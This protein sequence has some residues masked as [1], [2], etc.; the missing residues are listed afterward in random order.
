MEISRFIP[1]GKLLTVVYDPGAWYSWA[2]PQ[3]KRFSISTFNSGYK[4]WH[5]LCSPQFK[6]ELLSLFPQGQ[7]DR[8]LQS[9]KLRGIDID[10]SAEKVAIALDGLC[11]E[12]SL[13]TFEKYSSLAADLAEHL[14]AVNN[15]QKSIDFSVQNPPYVREV[16]YSS[17]KK[18]VE[19][20]LRRD[21][22]LYKLIAA[23]L[24]D[25][26]IDKCGVVLVALKSHFELLT[27]MSAAVVI[28]E[29]FPSAH[30]S[31]AEHRYEYFSLD[32]YMGKLKK[33]GT[34]LKI[35]DSVV[36]QG[37]GSQGVIA[38]MLERLY[39]KK[40]VSG[41]INV[42]SFKKIPNPLSSVRVPPDY[43]STF[44][45]EPLLWTR[46]SPAGC[47][48]GKCVFCA[49]GHQGDPG[50]PMTFFDAELATQYLADCAAAGYRKFSFS[51]EAIEAANLKQLCNK[52]LK[53]KLDIIWSCRCR[54]DM[55]ASPKLF[56]LMHSAGCREILFGLETI[57]E[58]VQKLMHKYDCYISP[59]TVQKLFYS[60][61]EA[62]IGIHLSVIGGF[63]S[64]T[65]AELK[66]TVE[67]V[68][69][70]LKDMNNAT[71]VFNQFELLTGSKMFK[72]PSAYKIR[73]VVPRGDMPRK[74]S[75]KPFPKIKKE[76]EETNSLIPALRNELSSFLGW[77][78]FGSGT[79]ASI[80][81][82]LYFSS[83]HGLIFKSHEN[84]I[85]KNP[86]LKAEP[87]VRVGFPAGRTKN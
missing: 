49:Q 20:A 43:P 71:Y 46:L 64:E 54:C 87:V 7:Q 16:N 21:T 59:S 18:L 25:F 82:Y 12:S 61:S 38:T 28:R 76:T 9:W 17:S 41:F 27:A 42:N 10:H 44:S 29:R 75:Y 32:S 33:L 63:P 2:V 53:R 22:L 5:I 15:V 34:L 80:I 24:T 58:R 66:Q 11:D 84:S 73:A 83:G 62:G 6:K 1:T 55:E 86:L 30:I 68:K 4:F 40:L 13:S 39:D 85:F 37:H 77:G 14:N 48:W 69:T 65:P 26:S 79:A 70:V 47:Y 56:R 81:R 52:I 35:F 19:Y 74:N 3:K 8:I 67:F 45:P 36:E 72:K 60:I 78:I 31:L 51:D 50:V 57:S 23:S